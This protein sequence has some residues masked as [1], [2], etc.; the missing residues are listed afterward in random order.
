MATKNRSKV[1]RLAIIPIIPFELL[2]PSTE[3]IPTT[4]PVIAAGMASKPIAGMLKKTLLPSQVFG[5]ICLVFLPL[6]QVHLSL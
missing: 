4:T 1:N 3:F 6:G 2:F 5:S